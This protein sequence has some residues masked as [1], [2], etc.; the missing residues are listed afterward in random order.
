MRKRL[1][2]IIYELNISLVERGSH[3]RLALLTALAGENMILVG[4][5]GTAK[6]EI[7]RRVAEVFD[8]K[9]FEYL[10]T[11]F[12]TPEELFGPVSIRELEKDNFRRKTDGYLSDA[13]IVFLDEI[14]KSN[15]S[16]LNSLL[17]ILNEK[18]YHN[19]NLKEKTDIYSII[20][21]SNELPTD[22]GEL[23]ALYDRFLLRVIVDY[24]KEP[25]KLL[26][27][28]DRYRG[29]SEELKLNK[30]ILEDI[31]RESKKIEIPHHIAEIILNLKEKLDEHFKDEITSKIREKVSDRK[32]V[33]SIGLLKT[34]AYTNGRD[35]VNISDT[36][37]LIHCYWN[38]MENR[39]VIKKY[40]FEEIIKLTNKDLEN[41]G[42]ISQVWSEEFNG[43]FR[44]QR[45]DENGNPLYY[46]V[47]NNL[48]KF[49]YGDIH[50][51]DKYGEYVHYKGHAEYVKVLAELGN[52][53][54]GYIDSGIATENGKIVWKYE[55]SPVEVVT[56]AERELEG[57]ERLVVKGNLKP[58]KIES[59]EEYIKAY[60]VVSPSLIPRME[61]I[62]RNIE[63]EIRDIRK[64][65]NYLDKVRQSL[66]IENLWVI[67]DDMEELQ[68][69]VE[70]TYE[71]MNASLLKLEEVL[72]KIDRAKI[73]A[74]R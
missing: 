17:T 55:C 63:E 72:G 68:A 22:S 29:I 28:E 21:A 14:F 49:S 69:L 3:T 9:Y 44:K 27:L 18:V 52:F 7:S 53:D 43:L 5:P 70:K 62:R 32:L 36:L 54:Y 31:A 30:D 19:G 12:T 40:I 39:D 37:L 4:P 74:E 73:S 64:I 47:D 65:S 59:Y 66:M 34:S 10:L 61:G 50:L 42:N 33:K 25:S 16:I 71:G 57:Y 48:V 20:S 41:Y 1:E 8:T 38:R 35:S 24:V 26:L 56:S 11:K 15:S 58:A 2:K 13:N 45:I 23:M 51:M 6:S 46:D 67:G 60:N